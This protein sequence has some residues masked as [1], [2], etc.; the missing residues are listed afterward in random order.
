MPIYRQSIS[1]FHWKSMKK[2]LFLLKKM[3]FL[4]KMSLSISISISIFS[5]M[6]LSISIS[7]F[8]RMSLSIF[9][10]ISIFLWMS[11]SMSISIF[12]KRVDISIIDMAYW[13]IEHPYHAANSLI[14]KYGR[15]WRHFQEPT[16]AHLLGNVYHVTCGRGHPDMWHWRTG[17]PD[18]LMR[19]ITLAG[20]SCSLSQGGAEA[21]EGR[22][23]RRQSHCQGF[24]SSC[25]SFSLPVEGRRSGNKVKSWLRCR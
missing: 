12:S 18:T 13:Y 24:P 17:A 4:P 15:D 8:S 11:L 22:W 23:M 1:I 14:S 20:Q 5:K 6:T 3:D 16:V 21:S 7:I 19:A 2:V 10:S 9:I 25:I